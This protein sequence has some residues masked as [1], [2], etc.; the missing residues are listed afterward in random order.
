MFRRLK[1]WWAKANHKHDWTIVDSRMLAVTIHDEWGRTKYVDR[2]PIVLERCYCGHERAFKL[3]ADRREPLDP[4]WYR[5]KL[6]EIGIPEPVS[7]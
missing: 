2:C 7:G 3:Y 4:M 5:A 1:Q 6:R